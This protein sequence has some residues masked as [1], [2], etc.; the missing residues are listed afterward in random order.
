MSVLNCIKVARTQ[1]DQAS[2]SESFCYKN[3]PLRFFVLPSVG[4]FLLAL[5][6]VG[7]AN[8]T[9]VGLGW[10][11]L[12][13]LGLVIGLLVLGLEV[14]GGFDVAGRLSEGVEFLQVAQQVPE[15]DL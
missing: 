11:G 5:D 9:E 14:A 4:V 8:V 7:Q 12:A 13:V 2:N 10:I 6:V 15:V 3:L 1:M